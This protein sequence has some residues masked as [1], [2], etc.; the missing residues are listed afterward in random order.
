MTGN[1]E[2]AVTRHTG[3]IDVDRTKRKY[4]MAERSRT[5]KHF[6]PF[7]EPFL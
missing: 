5:S 6:A 1:F 3:R 7:I 4:T 2:R